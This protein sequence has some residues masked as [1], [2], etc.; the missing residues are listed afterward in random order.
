MNRIY[1]F[2]SPE[3]MLKTKFVIVTNGK[4]MFINY[5][6]NICIRII[7]VYV[8]FVFISPSFIAVLSGFDNVK[9]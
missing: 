7:L 2:S 8:Y 1:P 9:K 3:N 4:V 6:Q 5:L